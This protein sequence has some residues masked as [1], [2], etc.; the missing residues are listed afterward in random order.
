MKPRLNKFALVC[1]RGIDYEEVAFENEVFAGLTGPSGAGKTTA[2]LCLA[3]ALL[4]DRKSLRLRPLSSVNDPSQAD[5]DQLAVRIN[6]EYGFAYVA[7]DIRSRDGSRIVAGIH[8]AAA[9]SGAVLTGW[10]LLNADEHTPLQDYL[11]LVDG[12][13]EAFVDLHDLRAGLARRGVDLRICK[14][15]SEYGEF[16]YDVGILPAPL[17]DLTDRA[18]YARLI[19]STFR[20]GLSA[21]VSTR[22]KDYLLPEALRV[23]EALSRLQQCAAQLSRTK[24]TLADA[25]RHL[26]LLKLVFD[27]GKQLVCAS[28]WGVQQQ[29]EGAL[30]RQAILR[31]SEASCTTTIDGAAPILAEL[32][33]IDLLVREQQQ[34]LKT[35]RQGRMAAAQISV[36]VAQDLVTSTQEAAKVASEAL[37]SFDAGEALWTTL[38]AGREV[39]DYDELHAAIDRDRQTQ[40]DIAAGCRAALGHLDRE[41]ASLQ[42]GTDSRSHLLAQRLGG[43]SLVDAAASLTIEDS[44]AVEMGLATLTEGVLGASLDGLEALPDDPS[45]PDSFWLRRELPR[46]EALRR[47]GAWHVLEMPQGY[48]VSSDRRHATLGEKARN[49][50][51]ALLEA[52]KQPPE[53]Q[54]RQALARDAELAAQARTAAENV[55]RIRMFLAHALRRAN[56]EEQ[57]Q[58]ALARLSEA[59]NA[60]SEAVKELDALSSQFESRAAQF[61]ERLSQ[62]DVQRR[63]ATRRR[64]DAHA[65]LIEVRAELVTLDELLESLAALDNGVQQALG[66]T[67]AGLVQAA[68]L[69]DWGDPTSA[70]FGAEQTGRLGEL[71]NLLRQEGEP[72]ADVVAAVSAN[73]AVGCAALWPVLIRMLRDRL[74]IEVADEP[75]ESLLD[76][77]QRTRAD[78]EQQL[79]DHED[80]L[81]MEASV[82]PRS[83]LVDVRRQMSRIEDLN[84]LAASVVFGNVIG[85][86]FK[87]VPKPDL[88]AALEGVSAQLSLLVTENEVPVH[89]LLER[90]FKQV[91]DASYDGSALMDYRTYMDVRLQVL[92]KGAKD[93]ELASNLS[94]GEAIGGG[95]AATLMLARSLH[96]AG[97]VPASQFTPIFIA[98]EVQRLGVEGHKV[99]VDLC[100]REGFQML[101][102]AIELEP[103]YP[104]A[105]YALHREYEPRERVVI[106]R[107]LVHPR[108]GHAGA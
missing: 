53:Q 37:A 2:A 9:D 41:I 13:D 49:A 106:R 86:Q 60:A 87:A 56:L 5:V 97:P 47:V 30:E 38:R 15:V 94:G 92:R 99:V 11:R 24:R 16:L 43:T 88:M 26:S 91:Y 29:R 4:P 75:D 33:S 32:S 71:V 40:A 69:R 50:R 101:V 19:E 62:L 98:D 54:L 42:S 93:W 20:G 84:K 52:A 45:L 57:H 31:R 68:Q 44:R 28:I 59:R 70:R 90:L 103:A 105:L 7:L 22:L 21:E 63:E 89:L 39:T 8:V 79:R 51:R 46:S 27:T 48:V 77:M 65:M 18:L 61:V 12:N 82:L 72:L 66:S 95:L 23:P 85:L 14:S 36:T 81:R 104:C 74:P 96:Q 78:L 10:H 6:R 35:E 80:E 76:E 83:V 107:A 1:W 25:R 58:V 55:G 102:T 67:H 34:Q 17:S 73:D 64:D 3:Y 100:R 108:E